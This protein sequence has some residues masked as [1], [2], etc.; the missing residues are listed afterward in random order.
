[1]RTAMATEESDLL[2]HEPE[3]M[4]VEEEGKGEQAAAALTQEELEKTAEEYARYLVVN[5]QKEVVIMHT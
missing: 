5:S 4:D 1:M 2:E 3:A